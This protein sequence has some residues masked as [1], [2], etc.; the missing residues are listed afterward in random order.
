MMLVFTETVLLIFAYNYLGRGRQKVLINE[1]QTAG[2]GR[3]RLTHSLSI[4]Q[5]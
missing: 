4:L 1:E 3:C 2:G 5:K